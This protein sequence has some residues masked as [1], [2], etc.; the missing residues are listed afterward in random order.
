MA[1]SHEIWQ[2]ARLPHHG[3]A[4]RSYMKPASPQYGRSSPT[5]CDICAQARQTEDKF[6]EMASLPPSPSH[7]LPQMDLLD[8]IDL[9]ST[10]SKGAYF[11]SLLFVFKWPALGLRAGHTSVQAGCGGIKWRWLCVGE[12]VSYSSD[13]LILWWAMLT[14]L[15]AIA[16]YAEQVTEFM[17]YLQ[18]VTGLDILL[19]LK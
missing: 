8:E 15:L 1:P 7:L 9:T 11:V 5:Y 6:L 16:M 13:Y 18:R 4:L 17:G 19:Q 14:L 10:E 3:G 12:A 2:R